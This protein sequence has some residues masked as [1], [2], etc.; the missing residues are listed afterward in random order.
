MTTEMLILRSLEL[1]MCGLCSW[2]GLTSGSGTRAGMT[3]KNQIRMNAILTIAENATVH[4]N[5]VEFHSPNK[6]CVAI[7]VLKSKGAVVAAMMNLVD[8]LPKALLSWEEIQE[9]V[10]VFTKILQKGF[11]KTILCLNMPNNRLMNPSY[12]SRFT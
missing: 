6:I 9:A 8:I 5:Q 7:N 3:W 11:L 4:V 12:R 1:E 2:V 10:D